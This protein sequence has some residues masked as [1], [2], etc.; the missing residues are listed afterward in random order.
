M[1]LLRVSEEKLPIAHKVSNRAEIQSAVAGH[2]PMACSLHAAGSEFS[3]DRKHNV[4][5]TL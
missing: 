4:R 3:S 5:S 2:L 1:S